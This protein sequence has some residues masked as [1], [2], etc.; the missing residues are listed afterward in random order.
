MVMPVGAWSYDDALT[1]IAEVYRAAGELMR[2][3]LTVFADAHH[4]GHGKRGDTAADAQAKRR[5]ARR[6]ARQVRHDRH[7]NGEMLRKKRCSQP[8][9]SAS[10]M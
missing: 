4:A 1:M 2:D 6:T 7:Q 10:L 8:M 3:A 9:V 5:E